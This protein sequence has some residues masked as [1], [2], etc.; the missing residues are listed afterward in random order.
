MLTFF[1]FKGKVN[2]QTGLVKNCDVGEDRSG[3]E[4]K[5]NVRHGI[6]LDESSLSLVQPDVSDTAVS[7][8]CYNPMR[9]IRLPDG[10]LWS[11][12]A[13]NQWNGG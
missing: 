4:G 9:P 3:W 2:T 10:S 12:K 11:S 1:F 8:P 7:F 6:W 5:K 13:K